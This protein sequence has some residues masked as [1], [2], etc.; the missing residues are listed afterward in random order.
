MVGPGQTDGLKWNRTQGPGGLD[1]I[2]GVRGVEAS[3]VDP[4]CF[5]NESS[6]TG[7][8]DTDIQ[9]GRR[10]VTR[11]AWNG[12]SRR[13]GTDHQSCR[14]RRSGN[15]KTV[16]GQGGAF[17]RPG[18]DVQVTCG[19]EIHHHRIPFDPSRQTWCDVG[20][21]RDGPSGYSRLQRDGR[22][23]EGVG[24]RSVGGC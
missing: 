22:K 19:G 3:T 15:A 9:T 1:E 18:N 6:R 14:E 5:K 13:L 10:P 7:P 24:D 21:F 23:R 20:H 17:G 8:I 12:L 11:H 4:R 2:F 16:C